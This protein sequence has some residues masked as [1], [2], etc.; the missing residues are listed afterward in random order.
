MQPRAALG[1]LELRALLL[2]VP[3]PGELCVP[4][5]RFFLFCFPDKTVL[6]CVAG[7][8]AG[9]SELAVGAS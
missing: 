2:R 8:R 3:S 7:V 9:P 5:V 6:L 4:P 1:L